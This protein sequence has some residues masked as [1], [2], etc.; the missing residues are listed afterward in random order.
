MECTKLTHIFLLAG[1]RKLHRT[2]FLVQDRH[3]W[4][5]Y[6]P[7]LRCG[8]GADGSCMEPATGRACV[9]AAFRHFK[10]PRTRGKRIECSTVRMRIDSMRVR[11]CTR[12]RGCADIAA[13]SDSG[14]TAQNAFAAASSTAPAQTTS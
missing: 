6:K 5:C 4:R 1:L 14:H 12:F 10:A 7:P 2:Y 13:L 3:I 8:D 9:Q 11:G